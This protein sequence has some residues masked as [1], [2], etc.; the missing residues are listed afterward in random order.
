MGLTYKRAG[1]NFLEF[2]GMI[3]IPTTVIEVQKGSNGL[4]SIAGHSFGQKRTG[5]PKSGS[6]IQHIMSLGI[7]IMPV[8]L[9]G[10]KSSF[11]PQSP[12]PWSGI[13]NIL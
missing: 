2:I 3:L 5:V 9:L 10:L 12:E 13:R 8:I 7:L 1:F 6:S 4:K 11:L